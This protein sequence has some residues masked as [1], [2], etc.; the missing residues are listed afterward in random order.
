MKYFTDELVEFCDYLDEVKT[1]EHREKWDVALNCYWTHYEKI[2]DRYPIGF[3]KVY[4]ETGFHDYIVEGIGITFEEKKRKNSYCVSIIINDDEGT[5]KK[6][7]QI[8]FYNVK[9]L[10]YHFEAGMIPT[11]L[12]SEFLD[13][14][15]KT[16]SL[17]VELTD[18]GR[19]YMEYTK[20]K[21]KRL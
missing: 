16:L 10:E 8:T 7:Y 5:E 13:V 11:W 17:E 15:E 4:T 1:N 9:K 12:T 3:S 21:F 18:D 6:R 20:M 19:L 2:K 14:D